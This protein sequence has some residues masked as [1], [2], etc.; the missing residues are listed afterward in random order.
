M[1]FLALVICGVLWLEAE[2]SAFDL[3]SGATKE[4]LST[5]KSSNKNLSNVLAT[6]KGQASSLAQNQEGLR[7]LFEGQGNKIRQLADVLATHDSTLKAIK[8]TQDMQENLL[9]QQGSLIEALKTQ[10]DVNKSAIAQL[11]QK[12]NDM[13][14]VL[15][16]MNTDFATKLEEIQG[17][18]QAQANSNAEKLKDLA[19]LQA[20]MLEKTQEAPQE[21]SEDLD[22]KKDLSRK[23]KIFREALSLYRQ[24][25]FKQAQTRLVWL[26]DNGFRVA[27]SYYMAGEAAY[28]QK[29][30]KEAIVLY[31]KSALVKEKAEYMPILLWHTA[32]SF[33]FLGDQNTYLKFLRSLSNLYPESEQGK[34]ALPLLGK[35]SSKG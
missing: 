35:S 27:Y 18:I 34:K 14:A 32:W 26:G 19:R 13:N 7:S 22:F 28:A 10:I 4:E 16:K 31:K 29:N 9:K 1:R 20:K 17:V 24:K 8:A 2:P 33:R 30:Y 3:Q 5:L 11:D 21:K 25:H 15:T 6:L 12:I 23:P